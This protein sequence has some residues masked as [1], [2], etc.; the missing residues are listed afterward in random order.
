MKTTW[1]AKIFDNN[2]WFQDM[3]PTTIILVKINVCF[4]L[5]QTVTQTLLN[6][7]LAVSNICYCIRRNVTVKYIDDFSL[8]LKCSFCIWST[9]S[10]K[11]LVKIKILWFFQV[12]VDLVDPHGYEDTISRSYSEPPIIFTKLHPKTSYTL[13]VTDGQNQI[14]HIQKFFI[15]RLT[16]FIVISRNIS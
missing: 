4:C 1:V 8:I 9:V 6:C 2:I 12:A 5:P 16:F 7:T 11:R 14:P 3:N 13:K 10:I 15:M